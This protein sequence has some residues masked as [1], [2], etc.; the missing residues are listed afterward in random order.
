VKR[1]T[2]LRL[3]ALLIL[4]AGVALTWLFL[5]V[6]QYLETFRDWSQGEGK[7]WGL[8]VLALAYT[9]AA[10]LFI[11]AS[12]VTIGAGA[13]FGVEAA[14][15]AISLGS[16]AG[17]CL[18]F[19]VGRGIGRPWVEEM[20]GH[21]PRFGALDRA[22]AA[23]GLKIVFLTRLSPI[24]PYALLN[25]TYS[26]TRVSLRDF[27]LA[28]WLGMLPGTFLYIYVGRSLRGVGV[29]LDDLFAGRGGE[30]LV[31]TLFLL[32]GLAATVAV[33]VFITRLARN[34]LRQAL[35]ESA[36]PAG[37]PDGPVADRPPAGRTQPEVAE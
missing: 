33:T 2:A 21:S 34:A 20:V 16:T 26:L 10:L 11:P 32:A 1:S 27:L 14:V 3:L 17:A 36:P 5:P 6:R 15:V 37:A 13:V 9:P 25:Y 7:V 35:A 18:A 29:L 8:V 23:N 28:S 4:A 12:M 24:F 31:Q 30:N 22:V 19:L